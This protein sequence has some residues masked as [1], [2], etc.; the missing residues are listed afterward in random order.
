MKKRALV[1]LAM[2][3]MMMLLLLSACSNSSDNNE[4]TTSQKENEETSNQTNREANDG[5]SWRLEEPATITMLL[6]SPYWKE[7]TPV[8]QWI[9]DATNITMEPTIPAGNYDDAFSLTMAGGDIPDILYAM[10]TTAVNNYGRQ[11]AFIDFNDYIDQMPNLKKYWDADQATN[12]LRVSSSDGATY[13]AVV[14]GS[15]DGS[16]R[17]WIYRKDIFEKEG[18]SPPKTYDELYEVLKSLKQKYPDS[19]PL[20]F[21]GGLSFID[22][23]LSPT[24]GTYDEV[25]RDLDTREVKFGPATDG[26]R[27]LLDYL[28]KF[29][30]EGLMS[31]DWL[32]VSA[33]QW[34]ERMTTDKAFI[35]FDFLTR[36]ISLNDSYG[37]DV[38]APMDPPLGAGEKAYMPKAD[39]ATFGFAVNKNAKH[40]DAALHYIDFLFSDE[41]M[42]LVSW[43]PQGEGH[44]VV[45]GKKQLADQNYRAN[46]GVMQFGSYG[47]FDYDSVLTTM[48]ADFAERYKGYSSFNWP[49]AVQAPPF[50]AEESGITNLKYVDITKYAETNAAKFILG[51]RP[52]SEWDK[53]V[54]ELD[55]MGL[56]DVLDVYEKAWDR[57][58]SK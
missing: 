27:Q 19:Y 33:E 14:D 39:V 16:T 1:S 26:Y 56:Q 3:G 49:E 7:D 50:T 30:E 15:T 9:K 51:D 6:Q 25:Y 28:H 32:T 42:E 52:L 46:L 31:P 58:G 40:L 18:I 48:S 22:Y 36:V 17:G 24:F 57:L 38:L 43:G 12:K 23:I 45:N 29:N 37:S 2:A 4:S 41:G 13:L 21:R 47:R 34:I 53:Y 55:A 54:Q 44:V 8:Y 35:T 5:T 10:N 20:S 11:G